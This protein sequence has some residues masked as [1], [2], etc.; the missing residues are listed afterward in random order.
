MLLLDKDG[1]GC[2]YFLHSGRGAC[3]CCFWIRTALVVS[4]FFTQGEGHTNVA[5]G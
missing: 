2:L 5:S 1:I 4:I 3:Q